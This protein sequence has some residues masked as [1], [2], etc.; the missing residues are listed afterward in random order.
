MELE[1]HI[2]RVISAEQ[3]LDV[4]WRSGLAERRPV[5]DPNC[6]QGMLENSGLLLT[7]WA[8]EVLVGVA[9]SVTDY[10]YACYLSDLAVDQAYQK[11]GIGK[12]LIALT[13][14]QLGP[15]CSLIL[16]A[17]PA[18]NE[19]YAHIGFEHHPRCW[20]LPRDA[21]VDCIE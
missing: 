20:V 19:Y 12:R 11:L 5:H 9:R 4:L 10:H 8:G 18:A 14:E 17:A 15:Q 21:R 13:Q 3:F 1:Y 6:I 2:N 7:A 16:L